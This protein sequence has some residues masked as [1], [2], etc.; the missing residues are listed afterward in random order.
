MTT[1]LDDA[2]SLFGYVSLGELNEQTL[3]IDFKRLA[4]KT[5]PDHGGDATDFDNLL[6]GFVFLSSVLR[7]QTGG[8]DKA[9]VLH[10]DDVQHAREEQ[11][12]SELSLTVD[13]VLNSIQYEK[14]RDF[15]KTFNERYEVYKQEEEEKG[16][17]ASE[18]RGYSDWLGAEEKS[19]VSFL[20]DGPYGCFTMTSPTI[21]EKDLH[22][23]F[24]Y[25]AKCGKPPVTDLALL[26]DQ[27]ALRVASGGMTLI[28]LATDS[29]TSDLLE[30]PEYSDIHDAYTKDNTVIDKIP[31]FHESSRT[32]EDLLK[33]RDITYKT[34][35]DRDLQ[36]ISIYEMAYQQQEVEHKRRIQ[37]FFSS[38]G[39]SQWALP[40]VPSVEPLSVMEY[41]E[42]TFIKVL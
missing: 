16:F 23:L 3:K 22:A 38:T 6:S 1:P 12:L 2:L 28:S 31:I 13:E 30:R 17:S 41:D 18:S 25:T 7:R 19:V 20:P 5:H 35:H 37:E 15:I 27:M 34:E 14:E 40:P 42:N 21:Q 8:R 9:P 32:F 10:P 36:A 4:I 29:F 11:Y 26:P 33:E 39:S 24:E